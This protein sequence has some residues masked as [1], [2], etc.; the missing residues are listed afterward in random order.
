MEGIKSGWMSKES[1]SETVY[2]EKKQEVS[3]ETVLEAW[4][5]SFRVLGIEDPKDNRFDV[6]FG[7]R[8]VSQQEEIYDASFD[9]DNYNPQLDA[10]IHPTETERAIERLKS[11]KAAGDDQI[12]AEILKKGGDQVTQAVHSLCVKVWVEE[13]LPTDWTRGIIFPIYKDGDKK[14]TANYRGITLLSIG[15]VHK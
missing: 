5:E 12:V 8:I 1:I 10:P 9:S 14:D 7:E 13:K 2:D 4:K 11:G 3:G 15:K 6:E